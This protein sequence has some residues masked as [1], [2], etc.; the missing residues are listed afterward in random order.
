MA[1]YIKTVNTPQLVAVVATTYSAAVK[2]RDALKITWDPGPNANVSTESIFADYAKKAA[3]DKTSPEWVQHGDTKAAL[4][5]AA[6]THTATYTTDLVAHMQME[7]MNCLARYEGGVY[8]LYTGSQFQTMAVG[9]L[10]KALGVDATKVR[11]HQHYLGGGFGRRL[12][13]DIMLEAALSLIHI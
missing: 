1:G 10:S 11:I 9:T 2:A 5:G 4:A 6:K 3:E 7:P 8:D 12:E 13:P